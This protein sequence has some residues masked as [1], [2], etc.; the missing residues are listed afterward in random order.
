MNLARRSRLRSSV[1]SMARSRVRP[2]GGPS[3]LG[4]SGFPA[5]RR[6]VSSMV[7]QARAAAKK[8][9]SAARSAPRQAQESRSTW[10]CPSESKPQG[11]PRE[12]RLSPG[13]LLNVPPPEPGAVSRAASPPSREARERCV[14][15]RPLRSGATAG[16]RDEP[17][18]QHASKPARADFACVAVATPESAN[19]IAQVCLD[20]PWIG[21]HRPRLV[22]IGH[23]ARSSRLR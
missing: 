17:A 16:T 7:R 23:F 19:S 9:A 13:K 6:T 1:M 8:S 2:S 11:G 21:V 4:R 22:S 14:N 15:R 10:V 18:E 12:F 20:Q 5:S 3:S